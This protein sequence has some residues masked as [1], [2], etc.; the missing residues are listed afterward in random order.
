MLSLA[1]ILVSFSIVKVYPDSCVEHQS[2]ILIYDSPEERVRW[3][4]YSCQT[5]QVLQVDPTRCVRSFSSSY[6]L[7]ETVEDLPAKAELSLT[8]L[9]GAAVGFAPCTR[10]AAHRARH[11]PQHRVQVEVAAFPR[12]YF[13]ASP[14][15]RS[16]INIVW[17]QPEEKRQEEVWR[18]REIEKQKTREKESSLWRVVYRGGVNVFRWD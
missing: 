18:G 15:S 3:R 13:S 7:P 4:K 6:F 16:L 5:V 12:I 8:S 17:L 10:P 2:H 11:V 1:P 14:R 9:K